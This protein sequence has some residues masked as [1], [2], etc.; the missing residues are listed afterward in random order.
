[1]VIFDEK[2]LGGTGSISEV[3]PSWPDAGG[4]RLTKVGLAQAD[5]Q[6]TAVDDSGQDP[7][8][9]CGT[10][11]GMAKPGGRRMPKHRCAPLGGMVL[12]DLGEI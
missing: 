1:M 11:P 7:T 5:A 9:K 8:R 4:R 6:N 3:T 2:S 10:R 12:Q